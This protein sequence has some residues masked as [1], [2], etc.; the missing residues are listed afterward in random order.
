MNLREWHFHTA[1]NIV[2]QVEIYQL[3]RPM[4]SFTAKELVSCIV[5]NISKNVN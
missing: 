4:T 5:Q 2:N 1:I 3:S